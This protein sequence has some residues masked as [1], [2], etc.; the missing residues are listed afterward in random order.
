VSLKIFD[1]LGNEVAVLVNE[2]KSAGIYR[3]SFNASELGSGVYF[4]KLI[5]GSFI[6]TKKMI[7][8]K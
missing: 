6:E 4:Y 1:V 3:L 2:F 5:S 7:L 8:M